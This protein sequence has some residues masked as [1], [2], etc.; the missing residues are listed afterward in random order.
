M[1]QSPQNPVYTIELRH[2]GGVYRLHVPDLGLTASDPDLAQ[3]YA[4]LRTEQDSILAK[5][6][7]AGAPFPPPRTAAERRAA[8]RFLK[9]SLVAGAVF[10]VVTSVAGAIVSSNIASSVDRLTAV[11]KSINTPAESV[12]AAMAQMLPAVQ[13]LNRAV[14]E[15]GYQITQ[16]LACPPKKR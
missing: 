15:A 6:D 12:Q 4:A 5:L 2:D 8:A 3:A 10:L 1:R 11:A 16:A 9:R 13:N 14:N 7:Q